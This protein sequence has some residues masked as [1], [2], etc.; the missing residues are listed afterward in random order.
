MQTLSAQDYLFDPA[1]RAVPLLDVR[2]PGEYAAGHLPGA[3][4]LPLFT[5]EE[6]ARVGTL[7]KQD[8]PDAAL[9]AGL[10]IAGGKMRWLVEEGRRLAPGGRA[11]VHC[12]RGGQ[13]SGSVGW[14]LERAGVVVHQLA[15]GYK[16][17]RGEMRRYLAESDHQFRVLSGPTG[18]GKTEVLLAMRELGAHVIDLEGLA[19]HKGSSFGALGEAPQPSSEAFE[20]QLF[21]ELRAVP[22]GATVWLEDESRMI[23]HVYLADE[24]YQRLTAA[25]VVELEQPIEWRVERLVR[26]YAGYPKDGL[27][28]A[29]V[30]IRKRLGGQHLNA[31]LTALKADD[32][33]TAA[34]IALG[35]YDKAYR[36]YGERRGARVL[37]RVVARGREAAGVAGQVLGRVG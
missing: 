24:F 11:V 18:S 26:Q 31:A 5:D 12:W 25:P 19:H 15:G 32:F 22:P 20:N 3:R 33:A 9:L 17:A 10:D 16:A 1:W 23:G 14:L 4:S 27:R 36:H 37:G 13:R 2:S 29:F 6:R 30:R 7:Y 35:Y 8:S 28:E 34:R 21:A